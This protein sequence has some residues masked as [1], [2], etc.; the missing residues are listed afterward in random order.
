MEETGCDQGMAELA[1]AQA[2][3]NLEKAIRTIGTLLRNILVVKVKFMAPAKNF[4]GLLIL[5]ADTKRSVLLRIRAVVSYNPALFETPLAQDWDDFEKSLYAF[6][7]WEGTIQQ[8]TQ[9]LEHFFAERWGGAERSDLFGY[10]REE[11][12]EHLL[13]FFQRGVSG[14]F[15]DEGLRMELAREELNWEQFRRLKLKE[16]AAPEEKGDAPPGGGLR[17]NVDLEQASDGLPA[18]QIKTGDSVFVLLTDGRDIAQYL[19][20]L[21]G[22]SGPQGLKALPTPV[23]EIRAEGDTLQFQVRLSVGILGLAQV[24]PDSLLKVE[25]RSAASRWWQKLLG[26]R[27]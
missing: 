15:T 18:R 16:E 7:L 1:M 23:E 24:Q 8:A 12:T 11:G 20:K 13:S 19:S 21:L 27:G 25:R 3:Y 4:Y 5:I 17:L 14:F 10:L 6:R 26:S 22:G 2:R 9:D